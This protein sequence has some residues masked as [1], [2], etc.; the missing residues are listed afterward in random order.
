[1][2]TDSK[3]TRKI[4]WLGITDAAQELKV[5]RTHLYLILTGKRTSKRLE[6]NPIFQ[7]LRNRAG[8]IS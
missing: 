4:R 5:S 2:K 1:M 7:E 3:K 8:R 6:N